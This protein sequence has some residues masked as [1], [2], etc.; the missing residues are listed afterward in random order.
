MLKGLFSEK[1]FEIVKVMLG[2]GHSI[3]ME[4]QFADT[5]TVA[6]NLKRECPPCF[7][8]GMITGE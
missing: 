7:A 5:Y 8:K 6:E 4:Q 2:C 3:F 1:G